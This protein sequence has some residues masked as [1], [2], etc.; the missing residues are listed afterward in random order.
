[1]DTKEVGAWGQAEEEEF[2]EGAPNSTQSAEIRPE[3]L[4]LIRSGADPKIGDSTY[5]LIY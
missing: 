3:D 5:L 4:I 2:V 1:M